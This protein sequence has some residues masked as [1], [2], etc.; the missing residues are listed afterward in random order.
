MKEIEYIKINEGTEEY[1]NWLYQTYVQEDDSNLDTYA[2][3]LKYHLKYVID[4]LSNNEAIDKEKMYV[5]QS[6]LEKR[7]E[8]LEREVNMLKAT[9]SNRPTYSYGVR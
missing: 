1:I 4:Y 5:E 7:V 9:N 6:P 3:E 2:K 8:Q